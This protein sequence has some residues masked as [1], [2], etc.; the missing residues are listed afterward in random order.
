M[1]QLAIAI[2]G[3][4][5]AAGAA[6]HAQTGSVPN[7]NGFVPQEKRSFTPGGASFAKSPGA[8][9]SGFGESP[10]G[11][12]AP[13]SSSARRSSS[14]STPVPPRPIGSLETFGD[15]KPFK[16]FKGT[17]TYDGPGAFKPYKPPKMK[18][19]YDH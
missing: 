6:A 11:A 1:R 4:W 5:L 15:A 12:T 8:R 18:S 9:A 10:F 7:R 14:P 13:G 19:V 17:S 16:P 2:L 3:L